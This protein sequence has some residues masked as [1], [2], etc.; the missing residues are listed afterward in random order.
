MA[1]DKLNW[2]NI[3]WRYNTFLKISGTI[4][5]LVFL[6]T[7][8]AGSYILYL[9][10]SEYGAFIVIILDPLLIPAIITGLIFIFFSI[11]NITVSLLRKSGLDKA[12]K[13][14]FAI[15]LIPYTLTIVLILAYKIGFFSLVLEQNE[16]T[17]IEEEFLLKLVK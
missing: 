7:L 11:S 5:G 4:C 1:A 10:I 6:I 16:L 17:P 15:S 2:I 9:T 13:I 8:I 3:N 14:F 12:D